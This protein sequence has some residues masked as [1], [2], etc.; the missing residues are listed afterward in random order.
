[1]TS[2]QHLS[3][4][5][6]LPA[7]H[8]H[9]TAALSLPPTAQL[10]NLRRLVRAVTKDQHPAVRPLSLAAMCPLYLD[11]ALAYAFLGEYYLASK[12]FQEAVDSDATSAV[13][14]FCLGLAQAE[15]GEWKNARK[16]WKECLQCFDLVDGQREGIRYGLFQ[17]PIEADQDDAAHM[18]VVGLD[19]GEWKLERTRV[20]FNCRTALREKGSKRLGLAPRLAGESRPELHGFSAGWR[21]GPGWE[22][23]LQSLD[24][25]LLIRQSFI[26]T[27]DLGEGTTFF[28]DDPYA[29]A[30]TP[31]SSSTSAPGATLPLSISSCKPLP[32]LPR[33]PQTPAPSLDDDGTFN[34]D[35]P[36]LE[37]D[38]STSSPEKD[39]QTP[40][41]RLHEESHERF[42]RQSTLFTPEE[43]FLI[44]HSDE[45]DDADDDEFYDTTTAI[46]DTIASWGG[47]GQT[48]SGH[49]EADVDDHTQEEEEEEEEEEE[50]EEPAHE[51]HDSN[52]QHSTE[53][54]GEILQPLVFEGFP[55]SNPADRINQ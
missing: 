34:D 40:T 42:S 54:D 26:D 43:Y 21:F 23:G 29:A 41:A 52:S 4:P 27:E 10:S 25:P 48:L 7:I 15:L 22:A 44:D 14:W 36:S 39:S 46:D 30:Q 13:G 17:P 38:P 31:P 47:L 16:S 37:K 51:S 32:A 28:I 1:M 33:S 24:S 50:A 12:V 8:A 19:S 45:D 18:L 20:E 11:L 35:K 6:S 55:P 9:W 5:P 2:I 49:A 53:P 3:Q